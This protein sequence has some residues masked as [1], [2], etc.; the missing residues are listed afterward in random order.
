MT[1]FD[2]EAEPLE[3]RIAPDVAGNPGDDPPLDSTNNPGNEGTG[4]VPADS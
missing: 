2:L 4:E 1:W 3:E